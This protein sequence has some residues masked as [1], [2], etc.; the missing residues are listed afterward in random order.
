MS[1]TGSSAPLLRAF[2]VLYMLNKKSSLVCGL[3]IF[4]LLLGGCIAVGWLMQIQNVVLPVPA[5][6]WMALP[7][8]IFFFLAGCWLVAKHGFNLESRW[9]DG[10][11]GGIILVWAAATLIE[12]VSGIDLGVDLGHLQTWLQAPDAGASH[13]MAPNTCLAFILVGSLIAFASRL[14]QTRR[15]LWRHAAVYAL[16]GLALAG[17]LGYVLQLEWLYWWFSASRMVVPTAVGLLALGVALWLHIHRPRELN[18]AGEITLFSIVTLLAVAAVSGLTGF[19]VLKSA[20]EGS[21]AHDLSHTARLRAELFETTLLK[22]LKTSRTAASFPV[23]LNNVQRLNEVPQ[24]GAA[25]RTLFEIGNSF[26][27]FG[28]SSLQIYDRNGGLVAQFGRSVGAEQLSV[29]VNLD[30]TPA[31]LLWSDGFVLRTRIPLLKRGE[32]MG[33]LISEER[34]PVLDWV[35]FRAEAMGKSGEFKVC[36]RREDRL[37]CFPSRLVPQVHFFPFWGEKGEPSYPVA[38]AILGQ[39]GETKVRD[40]RNVRVFASYTP[41]G[42]TSLGLVAK[43]DSTEIYAPLQD[44]LGALIAFPLT[45]LVVAVYLVRVRIGPLAERLVRSEQEWKLREKLMLELA[46]AVPSWVAYVDSKERYRYCNAPYLQALGL[47]QDEIQMRTLSDV[48]GP[49]IYSLVKP[50]VDRV[51]QGEIVSFER[52]IHT[53]AGD[54]TAEARYVP[55]VTAEGR[56]RGFYLMLWDITERRRTEAQL[57]RQVSIDNLTGL[58]NRAALLEVLEATLESSRADG[59]SFALLFLDV[60][61]FKQ[62]NDTRGHAIGDEVLIEFGRRLKDTLR[63]TDIVARFGGDEFVALLP[64]VPNIDV[65]QRVGQAIIDAIAKPMAIADGDAVRTSTSVGIAYITRF[66]MAVKD[67]LNVA[68]EALYDA[69]GAGRNR[70]ILKLVD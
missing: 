33:H 18:A 51:L 52:P 23:L 12:H 8:A 47:R 30:G 43:M 66:D 31:Q 26:L 11:V 20:M 38:R 39:S 24:D 25:Q 19:A 22:A 4:I 55:D 45:L 35:F 65:A 44:R 68:D 10:A 56:V 48:L 46:D 3:G 2:A 63:A 67:L 34:L 29:A 60:D 15:M 40:F 16:L 53:A 57:R 32:A 50:Y 70:Y 17:L 5:W 69:K 41:I 42:N 28:L 37:D 36:G 54:R 14:S 1:Y 59:G 21:L 62:I 13:R 9:L 6:G 58:L 49:E 61:R 64:K 7:P 27:H